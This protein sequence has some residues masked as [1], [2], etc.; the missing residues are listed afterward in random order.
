METDKLINVV[1]LSRE[2]TVT[3]EQVAG[4]DRANSDSVDGF[5][6]VKR[7]AVHF[8][9]VFAAEATADLCRFASVFVL[10]VGE[11]ASALVEQL[12]RLRGDGVS[13]LVG[14]GGEGAAQASRS[15]WM[16]GLQPALFDC[17]E[18]AC[19]LGRAVPERVA[20]DRKTMAE[21]LRNPSQLVLMNKR[22]KEAG[23]KPALDLYLAASN[24]EQYEACLQCTTCPHMLPFLA[25]K[26]DTEAASPERKAAVLSALQDELLCVLYSILMSD[27]VVEVS[28][29]NMSLLV[30]NKNLSNVESMIICDQSRWYLLKAVLH[31][32]Q[33]ESLPEP[34]LSPRS[35]SLSATLSRR[36]APP[37][38]VHEGLFVWESVD[39]VLQ[40]HAQQFGFLGY[41]VEDDMAS[42]ADPA[43]LFREDSVATKWMA[44]LVRRSLPAVAAVLG[45]AVSH[46]MYGTLSLE[47]VSN[48]LVLLL[49]LFNAVTQLDVGLELRLCLARCREVCERIGVDPV[50]V[51][52]RLVLLRWIGPLL[53]NPVL[54]VGK[55]AGPEQLEQLKIASKLLVHIG[56]GTLVRT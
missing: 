51:C 41:L 3:Q 28:L 12:R 43:R 45:E 13:V 26:R 54:L 1:V 33:F 11:G 19:R 27:K 16:A 35:G 56:E 22:V 4:L 49:A 6:R 55:S 31:A 44:R 29:E 52:G 40:A 25:S 23:L 10:V 2:P 53:L 20:A 30:V 38:R 39:A 18:G 42:C 32:N 17:L 36:A 5:V 37:E 14:P 9:F 34:V 50:V 24:V 46:V 15:A 48:S 8:Q 7:R 47:D 21:K